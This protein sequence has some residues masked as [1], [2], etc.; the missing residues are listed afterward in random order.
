L[1][2]MLMRK[3][4]IGQ[5]EK[6]QQCALVRSEWRNEPGSWILS[7]NESSSLVDVIEHEIDIG[8]WTH[9]DGKKRV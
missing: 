3:A 1:R 7:L 5:F 9:R 6:L 2:R 8:L 4:S